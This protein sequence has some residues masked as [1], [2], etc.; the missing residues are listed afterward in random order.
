MRTTTAS[1]GSP[2]RELPLP[3]AS[4]Y[5]LDEFI[6]ID[7]LPSS[8]VPRRETVSPSELAKGKRRAQEDEDDE[9]PVARPKRN[10]RPTVKAAALQF[11]D[12]EAAEEVDEG[13]IE[14]SEDEV[15]EYL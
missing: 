14:V 5:Q 15:E 9:Q 6:D 1:A 4:A 11:L 2:D 12:T 3:L 8:E 7:S 10:R 13:D